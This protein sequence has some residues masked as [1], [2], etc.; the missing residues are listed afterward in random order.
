MG[1]IVAT[2]SSDLTLNLVKI[3][4]WITFTIKFRKSNTVLL[5]IYRTKL[6]KYYS[7]WFSVLE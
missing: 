2:L 4:F 1:K 3:L 5:K 7:K 6:K